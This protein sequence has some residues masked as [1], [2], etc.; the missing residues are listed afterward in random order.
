MTI[1]DLLERNAGA[2]ADVARQDR[3]IVPRL[4]TLVLTCADHRVDP[5]HVLGLGLGDAIVLR[6]P[7]GR[8]TTD[9][10]QNLLVLA[11]IAEVEEI[12]AEFEIVIMH[13]TDCGM[14]RLVGSEH[15]PLLAAFAGLEQ[16]EVDLLQ[17]ADPIESV[18]YDVNRL[19]SLGVL[20][21]TTSLVGVVLDL[22]TGLVRQ[23]AGT[24]K[25]DEEANGH[26]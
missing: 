21:S 19:R 22:T 20:S 26:G 18:R 17:V 5:A 8:L 13:H 11:T 14:S 7:G 25:V 6:N 4:R 16:Q 12:E 15:A 24:T 9:V 3:A 1:N 2:A 10:L 23:Y